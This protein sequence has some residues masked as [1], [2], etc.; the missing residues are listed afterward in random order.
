MLDHDLDHTVDHVDFSTASSIAELT[1]LVTA[2]PVR[3]TVPWTEAVAFVKGDPSPIDRYPYLRGAAAARNRST[4]P[5]LA[6]AVRRIEEA[7]K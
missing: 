1:D 5:Q 7:S 3:P 6:A 4:D 2:A